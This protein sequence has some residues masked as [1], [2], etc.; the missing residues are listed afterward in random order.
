MYQNEKDRFL[1]VKVAEED[2]ALVKQLMA[3]E[4]LRK[5]DIVRRALR[6]YA[7]QLGIEPQQSKVA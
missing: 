2:V 6:A 1:H 7:K 3:A 5:S 4:R